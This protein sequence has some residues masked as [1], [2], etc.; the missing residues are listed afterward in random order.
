M[1][2]GKNHTRLPPAATL[3]NDLIFTTSLSVALSRK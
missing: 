3:G 2:F 1:A